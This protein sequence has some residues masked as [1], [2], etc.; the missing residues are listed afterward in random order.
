MTTAPDRDL[1][2]VVVEETLQSVHVRELIRG[3]IQETFESV[4]ID[5]KTPEGRKE[6]RENFS[7]VT[8]Y[9]SGT[10][11]VK[12]LGLATIAAGMVLWACQTFWD[13]LKLAI[14]AIAGH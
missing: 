9:R 12:K 6:F 4:G 10:Q 5:L 7:W 11:R 3:S 8:D 13:G 14:K 1:I 2:K